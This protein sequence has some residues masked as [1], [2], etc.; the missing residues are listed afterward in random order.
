MAETSVWAKSRA[1]ILQESDL[2]RFFM[3]QNSSWKA[4]GFSFSQEGSFILGVQSFIAVFTAR[5]FSLFTFRR[6]QPTFP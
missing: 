4:N 1:E 2:P 6:I 3:D 5:H